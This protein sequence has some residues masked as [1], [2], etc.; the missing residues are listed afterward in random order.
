[1]KIMNNS[2][3]TL[4]ELLIALSIGAILLAIGAPS[5]QESIAANR[6]DATSDNFMRSLNVARSEAIKRGRTM[7]MRQITN[8]N[9]GSWAGGWCIVEDAPTAC[10]GDMII[11]EGGDNTLNILSTQT[12]FTFNSLGHLTNSADQVT[13]CRPGKAQGLNITISAIGQALSERKYDCPA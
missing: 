12:T 10:A 8:G 9:S 13:L 2:G 6:I 11:R 3:F 5:F 4:I 7:S 1:M